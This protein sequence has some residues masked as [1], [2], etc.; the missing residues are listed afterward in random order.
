M[1]SAYV[2]K[3]LDTSTV[4]VNPAGLAHIKY[5]EL[6]YYHDSVLGGFQTE[7][8]AIGVPTHSFVKKKT[9][10]P[11][12]LRFL[13]DI[14]WTT[15]FAYG[16][17]DPIEVVGND[18][19][20]PE[21]EIDASNTIFGIGGAYNLRSYRIGVVMKYFS[22]TLG[23]YKASNVAFDLGAQKFFEVPRF[24]SYPR[25]NNLIVGLA[26]SN[27]GLNVRY[28]G[29]EGPGGQDFTGEEGVSEPIP[30]TMKP[31]VTYGLYGNRHHIVDAS[32]GLNYY[33]LDASV[34]LNMGLEYRVF[35][36]VYFRFGSEVAGNESNLS[37]GTGGKYTFRKVKY[38]ADY[39]YLPRLNGIDDNHAFSLTASFKF[40]GAT[41]KR[42]ITSIGILEQDEKKPE[43]DKKK[44]DKNGLPVMPDQ[45]K[46]DPEDKPRKLKIRR[47]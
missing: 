3:S 11:R 25:R 20:A 40:F 17:T 37:M 12:N 14:R 34:S 6:V 26:I 45:D 4:L 13:Y 9:S 18:F 2:A 15:L 31:S 47:R 41:K 32:M 21:Y 23:H 43:E 44:T 24:L 39:S 42:R 16:H 29:G 30:L 33:T 38:R 19:D 28:K 1:S 36:A 35:N 10:L 27:L 8:M 7:Y 22:Q 5:P 46:K